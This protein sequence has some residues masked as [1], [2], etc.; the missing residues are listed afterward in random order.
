MT[1]HIIAAPSAEPAPGTDPHGPWLRLSAAFTEAVADLADR[2]DL[3]VT[4]AP[5]KGRGAPG[6]FI[7][8]QATI[9]LDG[10][11]LGH[12]PRTC[13][14]SRVSDRERYPALWGVLT[15]EAAHAHHTRWTPPHGTP[16]AHIDAALALEESRIEAAQ[17]RRRPAD[18]RWL[19]ASA[20][21]LVLADFMPPAGTTPGPMPGDPTP[22]AAA[23]GGATIS[24]TMTPWDAGR[25]AALLLAR[26]DAGIL[27]H[28]ETKPL[29]EMIIK[30]LGEKRLNALADLW[31]IAHRTGDDDRETMIDLGRRWCEIIGIDPERPAP[32]PPPTSGE[33]SGPSPLAEAISGALRAVAKTDG[34]STSGAAEEKDDRRRR[35]Q[36]VREATERAARRVFR[37][38]HSER[39][40]HGPTA[41]IGTRAPRGDEQA[42]ARRLA[43]QLRAAAHRERVATVQTSPAPPGRLRMRAALAADAQRAAGAVPTAEPFTRTTRRHVPAPP[44]RIGIAC[45]VSGSMVEASVPVA[46]A[47]WILARAASHIPDAR[48]ATVIFGAKVRP[49]THPG[50]VPA[51]VTEF[52]ACD[53]T[54]QFV[55][56]V[57]ALD[58]GLD[59]SRPGAARLLV[60][61]SDGIFTAEQRRIGQK[62]IDRLTAA[63]CAVLWLNLTG[64]AYPMDGAHLLTLTNP[65]A[66]VTAIGAAAARALRNA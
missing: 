57:D 59:L 41:I 14:P 24:A 54:E 9:E 17:I 45:D 46:S 55:Q 11:H 51:T 38:T 15:H 20:S 6:C 65:A 3:T 66:T 5:G 37:S 27:D 61:V 42:A 7:P 48:S 29:T 21:R 28:V 19:R 52:T 12:D 23:S 33:P 25:A 16:A 8:A 32:E 63:G 62:R 1:A 44:L 60:V 35:E 22:R 34:A 31:G 64:R 40:R 58:G 18:R 30:I 53:S 49:V 56:A 10:A 47:A 26:T 39:G 36:A 4:C 50:A 13:D 2:E 43:R